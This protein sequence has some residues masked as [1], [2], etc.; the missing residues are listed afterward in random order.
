MNSQHAEIKTEKNEAHFASDIAE[1]PISVAHLRQSAILIVAGSTPVSSRGRLAQWVEHQATSLKVKGS[2]FKVVRFKRVK[3]KSGKGARM[4]HEAT[5]RSERPGAS[6]V[7]S[8]SIGTS[9]A[10]CLGGY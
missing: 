3:A 4:E 2:C 7:S 9:Q 6:L 8:L 5:R 10:S 1:Q